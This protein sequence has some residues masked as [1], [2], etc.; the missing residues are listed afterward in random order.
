MGDDPGESRNPLRGTNVYG[1][2]RGGP[3]RSRRKAVKVAVFGGTG[4]VGS[5]AVEKLT[6]AGL[7][8]RVA[9]RDADRALR[10][11][12]PSFEV[13]EADAETGLGVEAALEGCEGLF[14][15]IDSPREGECVEKLVG[16]AG[17]AGVERIVY[18]SGCTVLQENAWFPLVEG[19]LRAEK[20]LREGGIPWTVL[21]PGWF[22]ET[23]SRFVREG[24][25]V[26]FGDDP[27][28]WHF[29][30]AGDFGR[31]VAQAF[32][33]QE[34]QNRRFVVHGPEAMSIRDALTRYLARRHPEI[35][36][37]STPPLWLLHLVARLKKNEGLKYALGLMAYF[38]RVGELG[39]PSETTELFGAPETTL[40]EWLRR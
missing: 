13:A 7:E 32:T 37:I 11:F 23:L 39:D 28:V 30:A 40:E 3:F 38:E 15:S 14:I 19:K 16:V 26:L 24:K 8:V 34:A 6:A 4:L 1:I 31:I 10:H 2:D 5:P 27:N 9:S 22:F 25:A 33:T 12:G 29:V 35:R 17:A 20:A 36:K 18:V 21:A